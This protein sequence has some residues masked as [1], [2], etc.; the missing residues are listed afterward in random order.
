MSASSRTRWTMTRPCPP[1]PGTGP[2]KSSTPMATRR[3]LI[4]ASSPPS[5]GDRQSAPHVEMLLEP[6]VGL[7]EP[8]SKFDAR[9]PT[10][11]E[12]TGD[13]QQLAWRSV[14]LRAVEADSP[15]ET[16]CVLH[17]VRDLGDR[18]VLAAADV[19]NLGTVVVVE[20]EHASISHVVD[21]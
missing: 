15:L 3:R 13:V 8:S 18:H 1:P 17:E 21:V 20:N 9:P 5:R 10:K 14:G 4:G 11:S 16:H 19:E 12:Q 7:C 2:N 6:R